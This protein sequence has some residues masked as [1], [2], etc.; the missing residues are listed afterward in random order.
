MTNTKIRAI[1]IDD[2]SRSRENITH[3]LKMHCRDIE[4]A[5]QADSIYSGI[6]SIKKHNP[7]LIFL[8][9][10]LPDGTGFNLLR[11]FSNINFKVIFITAYEEYAI[12]AFKFSA[13]DYLLKPIDPEELINA[14]SK[15]RETIEAES[16][17]RRI[18]EFMSQINLF[19]K[20]GLGKKIVLKTLDNLYVIDSND[21][22]SIKSED[23]YCRFYLVDNKNILV[24]YSLKEYIKELENNAFYRTYK[25]YAVN[26]HHIKRYNRAENSCIMSDGSIIPVSYRRKDELFNIL[27]NI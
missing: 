23:N 17:S 1:I 12:K 25:S 9:I 22:I 18:N 10:K 20:F 4:I 6:I 15:A 24:S 2:E 7:D 8:D 26:L 21:I 14:V 11:E 5:D 19:K 13:M 3:I 16:L 27:K